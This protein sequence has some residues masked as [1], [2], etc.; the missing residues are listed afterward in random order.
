QRKSIRKGNL[1]I[2]RKYEHRLLYYKVNITE[3]FVM[4]L[5]TRCKTG[6]RKLFEATVCESFQSVIQT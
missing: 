2:L 6:E 1:S 4:Y 3:I 5:A